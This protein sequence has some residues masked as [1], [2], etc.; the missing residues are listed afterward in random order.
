MFAQGHPASWAP[1]AGHAGFNSQK[2]PLPW[3][4]PVN[5]AGMFAQG[6]LAA[7][8]PSTANPF[9]DRDGGRSR[10]NI[11]DSFINRFGIDDIR[12][13]ALVDASFC[14]DIGTYLVYKPEDDNEFHA[15]I[16]NSP[17]KVSLTSSQARKLAEHCTIVYQSS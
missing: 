13:L 3:A 5:H 15:E 7:L 1:S 11:V 17:E 6:H 14:M 4:Q 8:L 16:H 12:A 10:E 2:Q 9:G